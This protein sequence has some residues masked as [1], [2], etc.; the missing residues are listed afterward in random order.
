LFSNAKVT[1][2]DISKFLSY[3]GEESLQRPFFAAY[4]PLICKGKTGVLI[5]STGLPNEINMDVTGWGHHNGGIEKET[6]LIL[7][8]EKG[9]EQPLYFRYVSGNIGDV[10]TLANTID[11]MKRY[12]YGSY[13][14]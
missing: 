13:H 3:L 12:F 2:Q 6:R 4:I 14:C 10:S 8:V 11:E 1:S 9:S 7:A 5:D